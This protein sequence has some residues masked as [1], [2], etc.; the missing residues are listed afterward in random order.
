MSDQNLSN[1]TIAKKVAFFSVLS[2]FML[3]LL[4][5]SLTPEIA[6]ALNPT[7][8]VT[9]Q[10][11]VTAEVDITSPGT[12][13]MAPS[14]G[15]ITGNFGSPASG[16]A[17]FTVKSNDATGYTVTLAA[18]GAANQFI[19][20][21]TNC[22]ASDYFNDYLATTTPDFAWTSPVA[23]STS[24]GFTAYGVTT[25]ADVA[26]AFQYATNICG[27]GTTS[28]NDGTHCWRGLQGTNTVPVQI[29]NA[30]G[31]TALAG[32]TD[33]VIFRAEW[34]PNGTAFLKSGTYQEVVTLTMVGK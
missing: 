11:A 28:K 15:G 33:A 21:T 8:T 27:T 13:T 20:N 5:A 30:N 3:G 6:S 7:G 29:I 24:F 17:T 4:Y 10:L 26:P 22:T 31:P 32:S 2:I 1:K 19:C 25:P 18:P 9:P 23:G 14:F 16:T 34:R 12:I